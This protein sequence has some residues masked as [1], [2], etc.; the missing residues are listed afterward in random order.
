MAGLGAVPG[1]H[2]SIIVLVGAGAG[3]QTAEDTMVTTHR[4]LP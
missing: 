2:H 1:P 3:T 4:F